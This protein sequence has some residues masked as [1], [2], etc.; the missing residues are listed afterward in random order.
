MTADQDSIPARPPV[1]IGHKGAGTIAPP[2]NTPAAFDAALECGVDMI[3]FDVLSAG[4]DGS[5]ELMLAH[6]LQSLAASE[7]V[8][9]AEGLDH[10]S[11]NEFAGLRLN[12]DLKAQGF[13][14]RVIDALRER[15]L[16]ERALVSTMEVASLPVVRQAS[17][18]VALGLSVPKVKRNYAEHWATRPVAVG[19]LM[20]L[21]RRVPKLVARAMRAGGIDACM[22][23][24]SLVTPY[25]V[26]QVRDAGGSLYVW[27]V[28]TA[29]DIAH[30][31]AMGVTGITTND[32]RLFS[33]LDEPTP[34]VS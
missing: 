20:V 19:T 24:Q 7:A 8:T 6:D 21:R 34:R 3:E 29:A 10:L 5:G 30:F 17:R 12:V 23:H 32:P 22:A 25:F 27:T 18:V 2:G 9:L 11:G 16:E 31:A 4:R 14:G 33:V 26:E 15:G 1:R 13:E 28:D